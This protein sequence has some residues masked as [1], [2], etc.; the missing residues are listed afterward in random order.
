[1][2][3]LNVK[4]V[5][6]LKEAGLNRT[7]IA[8]SRHIS[9]KDVNFI[10]KVANENKITLASVANKSED[11]IYWMFY[12]GRRIPAEQIY[13]LPNYEWV[14]LELKKVGV[15]LKLLWEEYSAEEISKGNIP[16]KYTKFCNDY[17]EFINKCELV[18]H[19]EHKPGYECEVD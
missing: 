14:H 7:E 8:K 2:N 17:S 19:I 15:T 12:P 13:A 1:M 9:R 10:F 3:K 4:L 11:E 6:K 18:S 5:L 16:V